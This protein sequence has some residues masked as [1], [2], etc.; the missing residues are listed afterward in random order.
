MAERKLLATKRDRCQGSS[1]KDKSRTPP[2]VRP[3]HRLSSQASHQ[4]DAHSEDYSET[5]GLPHG[6]R[7]YD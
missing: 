4:A 1:K 7:V 6:Q 5:A 3:D 2:R